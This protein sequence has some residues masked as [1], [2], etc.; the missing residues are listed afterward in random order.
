MA[1]RRAPPT[2]KAVGANITGQSPESAV[3]MRM[4]AWVTVSPPAAVAR[5]PHQPL[6][7]RLAHRGE[8]VGQHR[9]GVALRPRRRLD[10][11]RLE[12]Q[13]DYLPP[14]RVVGETQP[15]PRDRGIDLGVAPLV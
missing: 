7:G 15:G 14:E 6:H 8:Q 12:Q 9:H 11:A 4:K 13:V 2:S 3:R 1:A 10:R 5:V